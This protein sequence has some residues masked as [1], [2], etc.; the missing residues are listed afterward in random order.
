M[1]V[2]WLFGL[3]HQIVENRIYNIR[4]NDNIQV[5]SAVFVADGVS[6]GPE[7]LKFGEGMDVGP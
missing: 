1:F 2:G 6:F 5:L 7:L 4:S 3:L